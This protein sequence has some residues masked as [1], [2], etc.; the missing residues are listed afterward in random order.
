M[1][2]EYELVHVNRVGHELRQPAFLSETELQPGSILRHWGRDW[3]V[4]SVDARRV[5]LRPAR[6]RLR[7]R[8]PDGREELGAVRRYRADAPRVGHTFSTL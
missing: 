6:Y 5:E 2:L 3:I 7:L 1:P 8:H 4:D